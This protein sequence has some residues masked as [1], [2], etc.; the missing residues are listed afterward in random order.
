MKQHDDSSKGSFK[1]GGQRID[2]HANWTGKAKS[3]DVFA[4]GAKT[5]GYSSA[6]GAG[7][8]SK[9]EDTT[10]AI[11]ETQEKCQGKI[12]EHAPKAGYRN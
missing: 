6:M 3:G 8:L 5:K 7:S 1:S 10:E 2:D 9:Y 11:K 4:D 12:R